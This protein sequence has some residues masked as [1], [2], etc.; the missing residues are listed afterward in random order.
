MPRVDARREVVLPSEGVPMVL[1]L[2]RP[3]S[4]PSRLAQYVG[5]GGQCAKTTNTQIAKSQ[6]CI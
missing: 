3:G 2:V 6:I 5:E 1:V 4:P